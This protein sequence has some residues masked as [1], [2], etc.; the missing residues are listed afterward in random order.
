MAGSASSASEVMVDDHRSFAAKRGPA[1]K[2]RQEV[3]VLQMALNEREFLASLRRMS[4]ERLEQFVEVLTHEAW[5]RGVFGWYY[6]RQMGVV[7]HA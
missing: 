6:Q 2:G 7:E 5:D 3:G 4:P 1:R